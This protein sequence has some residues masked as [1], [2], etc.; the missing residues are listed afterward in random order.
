MRVIARVGAMTPIYGYLPCSQPAFPV[1]ASSSGHGSNS[2]SSQLSSC[3]IQKEVSRHC[4]TPVRATGL[5]SWLFALDGGAVFSDAILPRARC[6]VR[7]IVVC[8]KVHRRCILGCTCKNDSREALRR[9]GVVCRPVRWI[10]QLVIVQYVC[11]CV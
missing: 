11:C 5:S 8:E 3:C 6:I 9:R 7:P 1:I 10:Q 2:F 4:A